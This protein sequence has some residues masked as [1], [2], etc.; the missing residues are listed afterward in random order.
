MTTDVIETPERTLAENESVIE[1]GQQTFIEVGN[2][3]MEIREQRQYRNAGFTDFDTYCRERWGWDRKRA[4]QLV[5]AAEVVGSLQ[6]VG[7]T[8]PT[9]EGQARPLAPLRSNPAA[10]REAWSDA[11]R[12]A[13]ERDKPVTQAIVQEAVDA[14]R[15]QH[16]DAMRDRARINLEQAEILAELTERLPIREWINHHKLIAKDASVRHGNAPMCAVRPDDSENQE[17]T[18]IADQYQAIADTIRTYL[19][20]PA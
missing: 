13:A 18:A 4:G 10:L 15:S 17:L 16:E 1:R 5:R 12:I 19:K 9:H 3:L 11:Q 8:V 6:A 2:A 14:R 20:G 7:T